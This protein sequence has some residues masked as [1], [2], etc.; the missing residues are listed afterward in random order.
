MT[1]HLEPGEEYDIWLED[2]AGSFSWWVGS[3]KATA[4]GKM[5]A[6]GTVYVG[7]PLGPA[8]GAFTDASVAADL[9]IRTT[10]GTTL[11]TASFP[12]I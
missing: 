2:S 1:Q 8:S 9:V 5:N 11:Q 4:Q 3:A 10:R 7:Q 6:V 12:G